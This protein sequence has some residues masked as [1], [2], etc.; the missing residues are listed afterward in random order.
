MRRTTYGDMPADFAYLKYAWI[1]GLSIVQFS[2]QENYKE[3][4]VYPTFL[5]DPD[6]GGGI[7]LA[8]RVA[9]TNHFAGSNLVL[10]SNYNFSALRV[11][12]GSSPVVVSAN[13]WIA[14]KQDW[15]TGV[16]GT[17]VL[18]RGDRSKL[19]NA[20]ITDMDYRYKDS[21]ALTP[22]DG[23]LY[24]PHL[25][26]EQYSGPA[27]AQ[28][29][30]AT[31]TYT[32]V[33]L[34]YATEYSHAFDVTAMVREGLLSGLPIWAFWFVLQTSASRSMMLKWSNGSSNRAPYFDILYWLPIESF[35]A[36]ADGSIDLAKPLD[37]YV[38]S[39]DRRINLGAVERNSFGLP[40]KMF[41]RN[42][43]QNTFG[44]LR[45]G[46]DVPEAETPV[47]IAGAGTGVL[48]YVSLAEAAVSQLW[49]F[50]FTSPTHFQVKALAFR[51]NAANLN[52]VYGGT[53]WEGDITAQFDAPSGGLSVPTAAWQQAG[54]V[55]GDEWEVGVLG[56][57]TD[58]TWP[59]DANDQVQMTEDVAGSP[60]DTAYR[61][62]QGYSLRT[63]A[64]VT[65]DATSKVIPVRP[66]VA[67]QW[68][69]GTKAWIGDKTKVN[70]GQV[71][72]VQ[73]SS[74]AAPVFTGAGLN[75]MTVVGGYR[76]TVDR[77]YRVEIDATGTPDTF[78]WSHDGGVTWAATGVAVNNSWIHLEDGICV[79]WTATTG[80]TVGNRWDVAVL[81]SSITLSGLTNNSDAF[82]V[83]A[84]VSTTLPWSNAAP[85]TWVQASATF[86]VSS[87]TPRR[88]PVAD[89]SGFA[90]PD[91]VFVQDVSD[92]T[93]TCER[94][95]A[96]VGSNYID[97]TADFDVDYA[98]GA[99][100]AKKGSGEHAIW[101]RVSATASTVEQRKD[102]R[103]NGRV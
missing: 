93:L 61:P 75:D 89:P 28:I 26:V 99:V 73:E 39:D 18:A 80:H 16:T 88:I 63:T 20:D 70:R 12:I 25:G 84:W 58:T 52:S 27:I 67:A 38:G 17:V 77:T 4:S 72:A 65:V 24:G 47:M 23:D 55:A 57:T 98:A 69:V 22:W 32:G 94:T 15:G 11:R 2:D 1:K 85:G 82:A 30:W 49:S 92:P 37:A 9:G 101:L 31:W 45:I 74:V 100:I 21:S 102:F 41:L 90:A 43:S 97:V 62:I 50:K 42:F 13:L 95:I 71:A 59:A 81:A 3:T 36:K 14:L 5:T 103:I 10:V 68:P 34:T 29:P 83:G 19:V 64:A 7:E 78:K 35:A 91:V 56:N 44:L 66:V 8:T 87:V 33:G 79:K 96:S 76:G 53:G 6:G 46:D 40:V 86:G 54:F 60:D 51:D 48:H